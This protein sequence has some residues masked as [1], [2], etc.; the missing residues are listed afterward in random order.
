MMLLSYYYGT[1]MGFL[2]TDSRIIE[3]LPAY[4]REKLLQKLEK[5][6]EFPKVTFDGQYSYLYV[7]YLYFLFRKESHAQ[8]EKDIIKISE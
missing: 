7:N 6:P 2:M 3:A 1:E 4:E 8:A 5:V